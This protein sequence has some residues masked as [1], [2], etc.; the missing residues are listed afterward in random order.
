MR[1][2]RTLVSLSARCVVIFITSGGCFAQPVMFAHYINMGQAAAVGRA[3]K[4]LGA[5]ETDSPDEACVL[6]DEY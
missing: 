6:S 2:L 5:S 4:H 1:S 3:R